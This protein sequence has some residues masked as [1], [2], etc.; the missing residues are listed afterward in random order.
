METPQDKRKAYDKQYRETHKEQIKEYKQAY[1]IEHK[2]ELYA[3]KKIYNAEHKEEI[4]KR[5]TQAIICECGKSMQKCNKSK[6]LETYEHKIR[7]L[8]PEGFV[9]QRGTEMYQ[10]IFNEIAKNDI[11]TCSYAEFMAWRT[12][13]N[14]KKIITPG[15][16]G[17]TIDD[18]LKD[19]R[20]LPNP[21][22]IDL[23]I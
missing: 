4:K 19:C 21:D 18:I 5:I 17:T 23:F 8:Y 9:F 7:L 13:G 20:I 1:Q 15:N 6:H 16:D 14:V 3:K 2:E 22:C 10:V 12:L 11:K